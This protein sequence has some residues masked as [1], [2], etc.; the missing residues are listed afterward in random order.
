M[1]SAY[2][3]LGDTS[4]ELNLRQDKGHLHKKR[5]LMFST[6]NNN[7]KN[8]SVRKNKMKTKE[9]KED[10]CGWR[11][12]NGEPAQGEDKRSSRANTMRTL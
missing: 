12:K 9:W 2:G 4:I 10:T 11:A 8:P 1:E 5:R 3:E 6:L 7:S